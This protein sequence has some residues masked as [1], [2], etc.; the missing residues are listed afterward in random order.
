M[1]LYKTVIEEVFAFP[2]DDAINP[3]QSTGYWRTRAR[4]SRIR[5]AEKRIEPRIRKAGNKKSQ[6]S[7]LPLLETEAIVSAEVVCSRQR[8]FSIL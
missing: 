3:G 8:K 7:S 5:I 2:G 1:L 6:R 4:S